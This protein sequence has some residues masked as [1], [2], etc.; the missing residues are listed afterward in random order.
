MVIL[1]GCNGRLTTLFG[2]FR[3][4]QSEE[5]GE[6]SQVMAEVTAVP[7]QLSAGS[8]DKALQV[9]GVQAFFGLCVNR[10]TLRCA[11]RCGV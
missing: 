2:D 11:V 9:G 1:C 8:T 6:A 5:V 7:A 4:G 3:P 10:L